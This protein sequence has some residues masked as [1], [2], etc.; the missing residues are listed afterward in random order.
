[1]SLFGVH[2]SS[3]NIGKAAGLS[4]TMVDPRVI[5]GFYPV[6]TLFATPGVD[7]EVG[8]ISIKK[9][10]KVDYVHL[11]AIHIISL[12]CKSITST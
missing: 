6:K 5:S 8:N 9:S 12:T 4:L 3:V 2:L 10:D 7:S 11:S 1:M